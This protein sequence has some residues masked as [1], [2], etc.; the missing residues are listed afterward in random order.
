MLAT[1]RKEVRTL[2]RA[3]TGV[4]GSDVASVAPIAAPAICR[5][6]NKAEASPAR[7]PKIL[8]GDG[9]LNI[10]RLGSGHLDQEAPHGICVNARVPD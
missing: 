9:R 2:P 3:T 6:P 5:K 8:W 4:K 1:V 7:S 10:G